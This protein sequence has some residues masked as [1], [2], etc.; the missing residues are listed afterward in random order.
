MFVRTMWDIH[1]KAEDVIPKGDEDL[2]PTL[3]LDVFCSANA[4]WK[5][6][7]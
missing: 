6:S 5:G 2:L 7:S 3:F 1:E 4:P